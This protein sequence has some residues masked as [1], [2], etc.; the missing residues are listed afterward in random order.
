MYIK[1]QGLVEHY[2][3]PICLYSAYVMSLGYIILSKIVPCPISFCFI[4]RSPH[5]ILF[6]YSYGKQSGKALPSVIA[7][8]LSGASTLPVREQ[9]SQDTWS[10]GPRGRRA[11]CFNLYGLES[12]HSHHFD[13]ELLQL[14]PQTSCES[15]W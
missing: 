12:L 2:S 3:G 9:K 10:R 1:A 6:S 7:L 15:P 5:R 13:M 4:P 8:R 14:L 11:P